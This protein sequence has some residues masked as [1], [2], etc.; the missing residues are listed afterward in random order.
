RALA[1]V[2]AGALACG[3]AAQPG[4]HKAGDQHD[5][6]AG[7]LAKASIQLVLGT[8]EQVPDA[9]A[10][11]RGGYGGDSYGGDAYG[12][13]LYGGDPYGGASYAGWT[14]PQWNYTQPPRGPK[15]P[16][17]TALGGVIE[18]VVTSPGAP[19]PKLNTACGTIDKPSCRVG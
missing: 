5:E 9:P 16:V 12:G 10:R 4:A 2:F 15:Y 18:G 6:G 14:V 7:E 13:G 3:R 17:A 19:P 11:A 8:T 1:M